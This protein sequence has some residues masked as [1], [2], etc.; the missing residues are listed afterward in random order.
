MISIIKDG[1]NFNTSEE[2]LLSKLEDQFSEQMFTIPEDIADHLS[3]QLS[4]LKTLN[5]D[6]DRKRF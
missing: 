6:Q 1:V 3:A 4:I 2:D 5:D